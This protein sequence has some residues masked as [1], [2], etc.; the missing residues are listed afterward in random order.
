[1]AHVSFMVIADGEEKVTVQADCLGIFSLSFSLSLLVLSYFILFTSHLPEC[2]ETHAWFTTVYDEAG[3]YIK[4]AR[5]IA[6]FMRKFVYF[7]KMIYI[8]YFSLTRW[9]NSSTAKTLWNAFTPSII[10]EHVLL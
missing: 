10:Q 3:V 1:M 8:T 2:G 9:K 7:I 4:H 6:L 5:I